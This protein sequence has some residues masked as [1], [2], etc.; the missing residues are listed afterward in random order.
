MLI[1]KEPM[2]IF[3]IY[4]V[5]N[6]WLKES[7]PFEMQHETLPNFPSKVKPKST[8]KWS[9]RRILQKKYAKNGSKWNAWEK[10]LANTGKK[11]SDFKSKNGNTWKH[12]QDQCKL[13]Q[14]HIRVNLFPCMAEFSDVMPR[15]DYLWHLPFAHHHRGVCN[16]HMNYCRLVSFWLFVAFVFSPCLYSQSP[17]T[18]NTLAKPAPCPDLEHIGRN[19]RPM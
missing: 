2:F 19:L 3:E 7:F 17:F 4:I 11:S 9:E 10:Q 12:C 14:T 15:H 13:I 16:V 1:F 6:S 5:K 18:D 8:P